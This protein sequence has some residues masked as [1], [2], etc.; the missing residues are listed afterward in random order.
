M[1][2]NHQ[3]ITQQALSRYTWQTTIDVIKKHEDNQ[4]SIK[5]ALIKK[6]N[7]TPPIS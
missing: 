2:I 1:Q 3:S 7:L 5:Q 6:L 4:E